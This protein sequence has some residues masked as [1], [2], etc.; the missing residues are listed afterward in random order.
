MCLEEGREFDLAGLEL[1]GKI[2]SLV[3]AQEEIFKVGSSDQ[4]YVFET[5]LWLLFGV[6]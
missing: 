2:L 4:I 5:A 3:Q 6:E 1:L